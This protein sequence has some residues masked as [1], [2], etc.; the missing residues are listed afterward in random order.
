MREQGVEDFP[1][2]TG[3]GIDLSD[4]GID[5]MSP[6]FQEA[7]SACQRLDP[8]NETFGPSG[9]G[10][11]TVAGWGKIVPGGECACSD[12]SEF[13][14]LVHPGDPAKV[15]VYLEGGGACFNAELCDPTNGI[16]RVDAE[17]PA[18]GPSGI[19][20]FGDPRNPFADHT[21][22]YVPYCTADTFLGSAT[23]TYRGGLTVEH[24]GF[25][26]GTAVLD[27]LTDML[28]DAT[29]VVVAGASAGAVAAPVYGA[30]VADRLPAARVTVLA[31][32]SG[33]YPDL[34][35]LNRVFVRMWDTDDAIQSVTRRASA[36]PWSIP[37]L[38]ELTAHY[39]P[40]V[41]L[42]RHDY[43]Y[44][45]GQAVW[46]PRVGVRDGDL[47]RR[48][49]ANERRIERAGANVLSYTAP[50]EDHVALNSERFYT[51][52]VNDVALV[53]WVSD[54]VAGAPVD[55]VHCSD[56]R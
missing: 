25:V 2:P 22:I 53:D 43:A 38:F 32:G 12:G 51:E 54:L 44:D 9:S 19:F 18:P 34:D 17:R 29:Q 15:V 16:Y 13:S 27:H 47:L 36:A 40:D 39:H 6:S 1:D 26:N 14:F 56:C 3:E 11:S 49:D 55:D 52:K 37:G 42:A 8:A 4:T 24:K 48:I 33:G 50:G 20:D 10:T 23:T 46:F 5:E 30:L 28:P 45:A 21:V 7:L 31:D 35:R 41:V